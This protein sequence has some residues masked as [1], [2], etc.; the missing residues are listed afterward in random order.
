MSRNSSSNSVRMIA[1]IIYNHSTTQEFKDFVNDH[2]VGDFVLVGK[3]LN[4]SSYLKRM[5]QLFEQVTSTLGVKVGIT[6]FERFCSAFKLEE[7]EIDIIT[8]YS[9]E[10]FENTH[11]TDIDEFV[12]VLMPEE[13]N[14]F[15]HNCKLHERPGSPIKCQKIED[16]NDDLFAKIKLFIAHK[17][18]Y[19]LSDEKDDEHIKKT[20]PSWGICM[21]LFNLARFELK[22]KEREHMVENPSEMLWDIYFGHPIIDVPCMS[23]RWHSQ[24]PDW[25]HNKNSNWNPL[26]LFRL[27][28]QNR[29][30]KWIV[31]PDSFV[32]Y[33]KK[34]P[35]DQG[36]CYLGLCSLQ[37]STKRFGNPPNLLY[38]TLLD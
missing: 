17:V 27:N 19:D 6:R 15:P 32:R 31:S 29:Y 30:F 38:P 36:S 3:D 1:E 5:H 7:F 10:A 14:D 26:H 18:N 25:H 33:L 34:D 2:S 37:Q 8:N 23:T 4:S 16:A 11:K 24:Y 9:E 35:D 12:L 21:E 28:A 20:F 22:A 13:K